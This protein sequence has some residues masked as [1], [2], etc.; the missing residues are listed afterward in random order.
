VV[1]AGTE[2]RFCRQADVAIGQAQHAATTGGG[3][4][5]GVG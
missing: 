3:Q 4:V 2:R 1:A 5:G